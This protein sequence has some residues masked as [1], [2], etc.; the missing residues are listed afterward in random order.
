MKDILFHQDPVLHRKEHI[1]IN[2]VNFIKIAK[3]IPSEFSK[4]SVDH[5]V[6]NHSPSIPT[7][8]GTSTL[9]T[10]G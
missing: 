5:A 9:E 10:L 8:L 7:T 1:K 4:F 3:V 6:R 2:P